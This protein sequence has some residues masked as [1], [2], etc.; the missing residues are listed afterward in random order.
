MAR[1]FARLAAAI[2]VATAQMGCTGL[3][4]IACDGLLAVKGQVLKVGS[5]QR[6]TRDSVL[7]DVVPD[8]TLVADGIP[9]QGC[10]VVLEPWGRKKRPAAGE[11]VDRAWR[12]TTDH[13]GRFDVG[14]SSK[15][16]HYPATL[17][18]AC[19]GRA[20]LEH[21]FAHDRL[22]HQAIVLMTPEG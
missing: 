6:L 21:E 2:G 16:G 18:I 22:R 19:P 9:L 5:E 11:T 14:G 12:T 8:A 20:S 17:T 7:V 3:F 4:C 1:T 10:S 15:P 13:E